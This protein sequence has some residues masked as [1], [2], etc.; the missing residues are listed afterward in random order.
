[1]GPCVDKGTPVRERAVEGTRE[2]DIEPTSETEPIRATI[3]P[4]APPSELLTTEGGPVATAQL[5]VEADGPELRDARCRALLG[6]L[7]GYTRLGLHGEASR[8]RLLLDLKPQPCDHRR[9]GCDDS[10]DD[11]E[12]AAVFESF[13]AGVA[14]VVSPDDVV[15]HHDLGVAYLEMGLL[16]DAIAEFEIV[17]RAAPTHEGARAA[18][19]R[20]KARRGT[21]PESDP[22]GS[23]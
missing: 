9:V 19:N 5:A 11:L 16:Q 21:P 3:L 6:L 1:M 10:N 17:L 18:L 13:K 12:R 15:T 2:S 8:V 7:H 14:E 4:P 22:P 20:A 23:A